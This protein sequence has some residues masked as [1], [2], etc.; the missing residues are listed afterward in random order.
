MASNVVA[1]YSFEDIITIVSGKVLSGFGQGDDVVMI[2]KAEDAGTGQVGA[3]GNACFSRSADNSYNITLKMLATSADN[4]FL[5]TLYATQIAAGTFFPILIKDAGGL[6]IHQGTKVA[7]K[8]PPS[9]AYGRAS[10]V[11]EWQLWCG[12]FNAFIGG[13]VA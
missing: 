8:K 5:Q 9:N 11:Y 2:E 3:D 13:H 12:A 10:G 4:I 7:I 1:A 6:D